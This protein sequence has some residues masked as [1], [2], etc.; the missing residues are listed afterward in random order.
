MALTDEQRREIAAKAVHDAEVQVALASLLILTANGHPV[1]R[2][3]IDVRVNE[4][5]YHDVYD[6]IALLIVE[7]KRRAQQHGCNVGDGDPDCG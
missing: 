7:W 6:T 1:K 2:G 5:A 4:D 3:T